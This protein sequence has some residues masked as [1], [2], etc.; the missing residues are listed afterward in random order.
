ML[1]TLTSAETSELF[2]IMKDL[3]AYEDMEGLRRRVGERL[4][5][6]LKADY[7]ASFVW[8]RN[9][10][11]FDDGVSIN[12]DRQNLGHYE[13]YFQFNDPITHKLRDRRVATHVAEVLPQADLER[14]EFFNDFLA[15]DGLCF[16][17]N[18]HA[19]AG[20][21]HLGDLRVWRHRRRETFDRRDVLILEAV[22]Q[23]YRNALNSI[24]AFDDRLANLDPM[25][26][27]HKTIETWGLTQ[28]ERDVVLA[29]LKHSR[30]SDISET[31]NIS[32]TTVRSHL[33]SIFLK[34]GMGGRTE[35]V[36][37]LLYQHS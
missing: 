33:K 15:R 13:E 28:R 30:D 7:F 29:L 8:K 25:V 37:R 3:A 2:E 21:S 6:L 20:K 9:G 27:A 34:S 31:L 4:L 23:A 10:D 24:R 16:G 14:T 19:Y 12:M 32:V 26:Q 36:S 17:M 1:T 18:Y 11:M 5:V 22:G 35:L